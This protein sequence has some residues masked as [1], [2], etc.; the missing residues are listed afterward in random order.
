MNL[1]YTDGACSGN[2]GPGGWASLLVVPEKDL[3]VELGGAAA[4]STNNAMELKAAI[5][6][7]K[8]FL[9]LNLNSK[10]QVHA[11][12]KLVIQG[13]TQ[14]VAGWKRKGWKKADGAEPANILLWKELD[15]VVSH[16]KSGQLEWRHIDAHSGFFGN[17]RVDQIAVDFSQELEPELY[18]GL[19]SE[20]RFKE[21]VLNPTKKLSSK[22]YPAYLSYC[23]GVLKR[24]KTWAECEAA[25][26]GLSRPLY[27]KVSHFLEE[28]ETLKKWGVK[29]SDPTS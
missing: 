3:L 11:D 13:I 2:P 10:L 27:K 4:H 18:D 5:E 19:L 14:W 21:E 28:E 17:E 9:S 23:D 16:F 20:Y 15:E 6:G 8:V 26:R 22:D 24:H 1:L 25:V 12:S 29:N 7:L